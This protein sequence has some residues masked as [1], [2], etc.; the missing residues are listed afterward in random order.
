MNEQNFIAKEQA[1][2]DRQL[3]RRLTQIEQTGF[4]GKEA[5]E[6]LLIN[7]LIE[8]GPPRGRFEFNHYR[9]TE[10]GK[11]AKQSLDKKENLL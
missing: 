3:K 7:G 4:A 9:L 6:T 11:A 5:I 8:F 10:Q 2:L 1:K